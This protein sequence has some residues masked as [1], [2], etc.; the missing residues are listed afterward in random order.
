MP[1]E[2]DYSRRSGPRDRRFRVGNAEREAV[3]DILRRE[4]LAGRLDNDEFEERLT[5]CLAAK[6][7]AELDELIGDFPISEREPRRGRGW[8]SRPFPGVPLLVGLAV[9]AIVFSH[10]R[11][12]WL[13]VPFFVWFIV[14]P[15][16]WRGPGRHAVGQR[17]YG[18]GCWPSRR[19]G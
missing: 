8:G 2:P 9:T 10:G 4:H 5:R 15:S 17:G 3:S 14:L 12:I 11:A 1:D 7:Y 19:S 16:I 13:L 6:T 18:R